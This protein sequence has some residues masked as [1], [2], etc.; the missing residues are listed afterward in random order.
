MDESWLELVRDWNAFASLDRSVGFNCL[1][2]NSAAN[3][4]N[5]KGILHINYQPLKSNQSLVE[6]MHVCFECS[7]TARRVGGGDEL[8]HRIKSSCMRVT[9]HSNSI[10]QSI[11]WSSGRPNGAEAGLHYKDI[12]FPSLNPLHHTIPLIEVGWEN[13]KLEIPFPSLV[14]LHCT[15]TFLQ[16]ET[17]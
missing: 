7:H 11:F 17:F 4:C 9:N 1:S 16:I 15:I 3:F 14:M 12:T 6:D 13:S 5:Q 8:V 2:I 10:N